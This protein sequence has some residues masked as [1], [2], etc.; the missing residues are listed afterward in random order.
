M[1][2]ALVQFQLEHG[3]EN[4]IAFFRYELMHL[5]KISGKS[6]YHKLIKDL[7]DFGNIYNSPSGKGNRVVNYFSQRITTRKTNPFTLIKERLC[8]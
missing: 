8:R 7:S 5:A 4:P 6:T 1:Y 3:F 2:A